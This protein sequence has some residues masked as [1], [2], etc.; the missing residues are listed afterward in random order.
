MTTY[1]IGEPAKRLGV[2]PYT[3]RFY[4]KQGILPFVGRDDVGNRVFKESDFAWLNLIHCFKKSGLPI[5]QIKSYMEWCLEG[6]STLNIRLEY[7]RKHKETVQQQMDELKAVM[8]T[9]DYK[10][11][12]Y[13]TAVEAGTEKVHQ[14]EK[15]GA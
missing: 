1:T 2:T 7:M 14:Q 6:D 5:K 13:E 11:W 15:Q 10:I 4:D 8:E 12:Y 3:L 9:V